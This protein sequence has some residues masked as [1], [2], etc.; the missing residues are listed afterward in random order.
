MGSPSPHGQAGP[1]IAS[2]F[3]PGGCVA[4]D[5]QRG[6]A[7][8][9]LLMI[10]VLA[11]SSFLL[12]RLTRLNIRP[13]QSAENTRV[14]AE[15]K[16]ALL[17]WA[18][19]QPAAGSGFPGQ[20]P[21]PDRNADAGG[22]D[23]IAD[24]VTN[25][26]NY[27]NLIG[28]FPERGNIGAVGCEDFPMGLQLRDAAGERLWYAVSRNLVYNP[29]PLAAPLNSLLLD[30]RPPPYPWLTVR[31]A[32]GNIVSDRV[33]AVIIAPGPALAGQD[34]N[35]GAPA[36]GADKFLDA[37]TTGG[38]VYSNADMDGCRDDGPCP[39]GGED[40]E[41]FIQG[42]VSDSYN[43]RL[44]FV[45]IDELMAGVEQRVLGEAARA[46]RAYRDGV[47]GAF[48]WLSP[49]GNPLLAD[50]SLRGIADNQAADSVL[51]LDDDLDFGDAGAAAGD[52]LLNRDDRSTGVVAAVGPAGI[53][54]LN[55]DRLLGGDN[56]NFDD[57]DAYTLYRA[58]LGATG[59]AD[60]GSDDAVLV[61]ADATG[62]RDMGVRPGQVL[63][64]RDNGRAALVNRVDATRLLVNP[65]NG[66]DLDPGEA[67]ALAAGYGQADAGT[68]GLTLVDDEGL[69]TGVANLRG[70][71]S[72]FNSD[73]RSSG[74]IGTLAGPG[75]LTLEGL[76]G[77]VDNVLEPGDH[78][79]V[80]W[81]EAIPGTRAGRLP[82]M[83]FMQSFR[84]GFDA[85][86]QLGSQQTLAPPPGS[87][88]DYRDRLFLRAVS[89]DNVFG[90]GQVNPEQGVCIW[91]GRDTV[92]CQARVEIDFLV[93][94]A[95]ADSADG[96]ISDPAVFGADEWNAEPGSRV[97]VG[98]GISVAGVAGAQTSDVSL[99]DPGANFA[100]AGV[101]PGHHVQNQVT[102]EWGVVNSVVDA[103]HLGIR[104]YD[105]G[106][107]EPGQAYRIRG[108]A[109]RVFTGFQPGG[110]LATV[111]T[112]DTDA[113]ANNDFYQVELATDK[114]TGQLGFLTRDWQLHD[115]LANFPVTQGVQIGDV[116]HNVTT[117]EWGFVTGVSNILLTV[118][119]MDGGGLAEGQSYEIY[120]N[121][122]ERRRYTYNFALVPAAAT[123]VEG[124]DGQKTLRT[125][126][127]DEPLTAIPIQSYRPAPGLENTYVLLEDLD[128]AGDVVGSVR[129]WANENDN[130]K[131]ELAG[132]ALGLEEC[133]DAAECADP[134]ALKEL[135]GWFVEQGWH[136]LV[137]AA[138]SADH[139]PEGGGDCRAAGNCLALQSDIGLVPPPPGPNQ[140][141][142]DIEALV[143]LPGAQLALQDRAG[144][145]GA[146]APAYLCDYLEG[147]NQV[148]G[149][150]IFVSAIPSAVANDRL[151][152]VS[153]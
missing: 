19:G 142:A 37:V 97:V 72:L 149:D 102:G 20:L 130:V 87:A 63:V 35:D 3:A 144:G 23:G 54:T 83:V 96:R 22:Y 103:A 135:P 65:Q 9:V 118:N 55:V 79:A 60:L 120:K 136:R 45:T 106:S 116:V 80:A 105:G 104:M 140:I 14:L 56:N 59:T 95:K 99:H 125:A 117:N 67:Y 39:P 112:P 69:F 61:D 25:L 127:G 11:M 143:A 153:P 32:R 146:C 6:A 71:Q 124:R 90:G 77:G 94:T 31:D 86:W 151:R 29:G 152:V 133:R 84:S 36:P 51:L 129:A 93:S 74:L 139:V 110:T 17:G 18:A 68:A 98:G 89:S 12:D 58:T 4:A 138:V 43:D 81:S 85:R 111:G 53:H 48:P 50:R 101:Q 49:F 47:A 44:V 52:R 137:Y 91:M 82:L 76:A 28:V 40:G 33:A 27:A 122:V 8:L 75:S 30:L 64:N 62:F 2:R 41:D 128:E 57:G 148:E 78:Y 123:V 131:L 21:Y 26:V 134:A 113:I 1:R 121:F 42:N 13:F 115:P 70:G 107:L 92:A 10:V 34:R 108:N 46:L 109:R 73:D 132:I 7:L 114:V 141:R 88:L 145:G 119:M 100:A 5:R 16:Q 24:C 126:N 15:A 66:I 150:D 38:A 147:E